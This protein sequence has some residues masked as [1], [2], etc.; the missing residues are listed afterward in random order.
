MHLY[1]TYVYKRVLVVE[2]IIFYILYIH[3]SLSYSL[4]CTL[5]RFI[6]ARVYVKDRLFYVC[7]YTDLSKHTS[8]R[9]LRDYEPTE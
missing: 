1:K 8:V 3:A 9:R 2:D 7:L 5:Y 6:I 4:P